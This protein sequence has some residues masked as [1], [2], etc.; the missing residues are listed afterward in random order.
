M[1]DERD[2][3][4]DS[5]T[6]SSAAWNP[7]DLPKKISCGFE[8]LIRFN[9][10]AGSRTLHCLTIMSAC[11]FVPSSHHGDK[12][13]PSESMEANRASIR[14]CDR[15]KCSCISAGASSTKRRWDASASIGKWS[16]SCISAVRCQATPS[17]SSSS[18]HVR[19]AS[20]ALV[21]SPSLA[22]ASAF[23][24]QDWLSA[25]SSATARS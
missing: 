4:Q 1:A 9:Y 7:T 3:S 13:P 8:E 20:K 15:H 24:L 21:W 19:L 6:A 22:C 14:T 25:P 16:A 11:P 17:L 2:T 12:A 18:R 5:P 10:V 23:R